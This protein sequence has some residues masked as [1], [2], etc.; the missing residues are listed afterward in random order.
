MRQTATTAMLVT[1]SLTLSACS[2]T[3]P[4]NPRPMQLLQRSINK[5]EGETM[6]R[7]G[8]LQIR[9]SGPMAHLELV[10]DHGS[11]RIINPD[12]FGLMQQ[13]NRSVRLKVRLIKKAIGP[14]FP[15]EVE[16]ISVH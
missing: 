1:V 5:P 3:A 11:Y 14:G 16:V 12:T 13:Q 15:A 9:G 10:T 8:T 4:H 6:T 7:S 2:Q